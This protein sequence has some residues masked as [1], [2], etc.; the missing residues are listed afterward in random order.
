MPDTPVEELSEA[1]V[2]FYQ[3]MSDRIHTKSIYKGLFFFLSPSLKSDH[4]L[5]PG[6]PHE[7][8]DLLMDYAEKYIMI[9]LYRTLFCPLTTDDEDKDL[10]IQTRIRSLHWINVHLLDAQINELQG[11]VGEFIEKA[12][13][14]KWLS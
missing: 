5:S 10:A 3:S 13:T 9:R 7:S 2:N 6:I 4:N 12:I 8:L 1:V 14:C 11:R